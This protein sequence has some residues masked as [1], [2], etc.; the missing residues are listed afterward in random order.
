M[1]RQTL[2]LSKTEKIS[3]HDAPIIRVQANFMFQV[4]IEPDIKCIQFS[5]NYGSTLTYM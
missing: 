5:L 2:N 1:Y 4:P 3:D